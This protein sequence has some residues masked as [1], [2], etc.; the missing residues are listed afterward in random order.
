MGRVQGK[1]VVVTGGASGI[2]AA[3]CHLLAREGAQV[4]VAD[5]RAELGEAV[6]AQI[7]AQGGQAIYQRLD[8]RLESDWS[9]LVDAVFRTFGKLHG[10][11]NNAGVAVP[12]GD[13]E[14]QTLEEWRTVMAVNG[15]GVFLGV[16]YGIAAIR[17]TGE[18]G[19]IINISSIMGLVG[20]ATTSA[21]C[22]SKGAVRLLTK[23]AALHCARSGYGIRINSIHP[24]FISTNMIAGDAG[25]QHDMPDLLRGLAAATPMGRLGEGD[26]IAY[27]VVYLT[28]DESRYITGTELVIDGGYTAQ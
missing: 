13:I 19:S 1:T 6:A 4:V 16:K 8:V 11:V 14:S 12:R 3:S 27:G 26:D 24:G 7:V 18:S 9:A 22:A 25:H 5:I 10:V 20:W 28:S 21:Y 17:R 23:S 15:E 2:G